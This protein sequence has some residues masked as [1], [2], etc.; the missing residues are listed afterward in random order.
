MD[1]A[2]NGAVSVGNILFGF[3]AS[4]L[5]RIINSGNNGNGN[6]V[7]NDHDG[8]DD[9]DDDDDDYDY[10]EYIKNNNEQK[11]LTS[12][13]HHHHHHRKAEEINKTQQTKNIDI[14]SS[15]RALVYEFNNNL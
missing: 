6:D 11:M 5:D 1:V 15:M 9:D 14:D 7:N 3:G 10:D 12:T 4:T 13:L 8:V 2:T